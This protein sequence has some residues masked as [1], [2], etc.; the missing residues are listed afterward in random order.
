[1]LLLQQQVSLLDTLHEVLDGT[2]LNIKDRSADVAL[3]ESTANSRGGP[4]GDGVNEQ[5]GTGEE[6]SDNSAELVTDCFELM[7]N[8]SDIRAAWKKQQSSQLLERLYGSIVD[9]FVYKFHFQG[10]DARQQTESLL[11]LLKSYDLDSVVNFF[12]DINP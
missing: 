2:E 4:T 11:A 7:N 10:V 5:Q 3:L 8:E 6:A 12:M 1:M 9:L